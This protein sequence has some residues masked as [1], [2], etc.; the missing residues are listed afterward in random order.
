MRRFVQTAAALLQN[1]YLAFPW[2]RNLYQ[3]PLKKICTPGL[4]CYSCPAAVLAC[5]LGTLQHFLASV[6]PALRWGTYRMGFYVAGFLLAVGLV[7]GRLVCG[8]ICPFGFLQEGLH[9]IPSPKMGVPRW[10]GGVRYVVLAVF[11]VGLP[12][13][14]AGPM[15]YGEAWFC[16]TICPAGTLEAGGMFFIIPELREQIGLVFSVK[17]AILVGFVVWAVL[18]YRPYCR[19]LCPLGALYGLFNRW[20]LIRVEHTPGLCRGCQ[21]CVEA[22]PVGLDPRTESSTPACLRCLTCSIRACP[23]AALRV[24]VGE[25]R[26]GRDPCAPPST[27]AS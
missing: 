8:W 4:N 27:P 9:R 11:V 17:M 19:T 15:G 23:A 10:L 18:S 20:S 2:T 1:A 3:G 7:G 12:L 6:R 24:A 16:R 14:L 5:P 13:A 25:H 22:C 26:L 21:R